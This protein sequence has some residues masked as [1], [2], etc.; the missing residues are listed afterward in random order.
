MDIDPTTRLALTAPAM[1]HE[2]LDP[3]YSPVEDALLAHLLAMNDAGLDEDDRIVSVYILSNTPFGRLLLD[4]AK[5]IWPALV[6]QGDAMEVSKIL[7]TIDDAYL[8]GLLFKDERFGRD[9]EIHHWEHCGGFATDNLLARLI[10]IAQGLEREGSFS[11]PEL[12]RIKVVR[13]CLEKEREME[14]YASQRD[15]R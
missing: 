11:K 7:S 9:P 14:R 6:V 4:R 10:E 5:L 2:L 1:I 8:L 13:K 15:E 12:K 3:V